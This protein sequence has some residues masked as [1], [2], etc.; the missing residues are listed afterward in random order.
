MMWLELDR[1]VPQA[2]GT[3]DLVSRTRHGV[4]SAVHGRPWTKIAKTTPCKVERATARIS[5]VPRKP[6]DKG[7]GSTQAT[8]DW[9][10]RLQSEKISETVSPAKQPAK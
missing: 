6:R 1:F 10:C 4:P 2:R 3:D 8:L 7:P 9:P 5:E